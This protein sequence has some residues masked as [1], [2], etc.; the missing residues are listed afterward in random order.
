MYFSW[1]IFLIVLLLGMLQIAVG[2]LL[3][4]C[5]PIGM[6]KSAKPGDEPADIAQAR[7]DP[8]THLPNRLALD[9]ELVCRIAG[10]QR[11]AT[12]LHLLVI[13]IDRFQKLNDR[14]GH[15]AGDHVLRRIA[16]VL[17]GMLPEIDMV[18][19]IGGDRFAVILSAT[20]AGDARR[21]SEAVR[22]AVGAEEFCCEKARFPLSVSLGLAS[23]QP[24]D[25]PVSLV[26]RAEEALYAAKRAG[27]NGAYFHKGKSP[28]PMQLSD[29]TGHDL[30]QICLDL[31]RRVIQVA[32][33]P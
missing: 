17:R 15:L 10:W 30:P 28:R 1:P 26:R 12:P 31:R 22:T 11:T 25:E 3:G 27:R 33:A 24:G 23:A 5:L 18:A 6:S 14:H 16:E 13:D 29:Q 2:V 7:T 19:R 9:D 21:L 4:R 8:L 32:D 20:N